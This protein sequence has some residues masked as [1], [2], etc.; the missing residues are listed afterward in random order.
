MRLHDAI[1]DLQKVNI[2]SGGKN[3]KS[4]LALDESLPVLGFGIDGGD[5]SD[6]SADD[7]RSVGRLYLNSGGGF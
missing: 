1:A 2:N 6:E 7:V 4:C 5:L 3:L